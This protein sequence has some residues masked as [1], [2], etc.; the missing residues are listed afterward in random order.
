MIAAWGYP[1]PVYPADPLTLDAG[2]ST[3]RLDSHIEY[4]K[5]APHSL[6]IEQAS[7]HA[8]SAN[9]S[10]T[11][12][13]RPAFGYTRD[14]VWIRF[15]IENST[16]APAEIFIEHEYPLIDSLDFYIPSPHGYSAVRR[17]DHLPF[18]NRD[19]NYRNQVF[20]LSVPP[21]VS[22]YY[23]CMQSRGSISASMVAWAP[24]K[25]ES[26]RRY[27]LPLL[28]VYYGIMLA[29]AFY[30]L[31]IFVT[32]KEKSYAYLLFFILSLAIVSLVHSGLASQY[33]WPDSPR[34]SN[35]SHP[36]FS[37]L[38]I[39]FGLQFTCAFLNVS[40]HSPRIYRVCL[41]WAHILLGISVSSLWVDYY[42][43]TQLSAIVAGITVAM[44]TLLGVR[45]L[46]LKMREAYFY[47][48]AW[49]SFILGILLLV[50]KSYALV[51]EMFLTTWGY[52]VGSSITMLLFSFG[53]ADKMNTYR[54]E[55]MKALRRLRESEER[56]RL[57]V[58][59]AHDG[60]MLLM[61]VK[62]VYANASL[63]RMLGY[64]EREFSR[65]TLADLLPETPKGREM[66]FSYYNNRLAGLEAPSQ[67]EAQMLTKRNE[68]IDVI[69]AASRI[70]IDE[71]VGA[72]SIITNIS[73]MKRAEDTI[74]MQFREIQV[75]Y[76]RLEALNKRLLSAH[77][78]LLA[79]NEN[80]TREKERIAATL[81][82]IGDAVI[83]IDIEGGVLLMNPSAERLTGHTVEEAGAK[84][85]AD[86][87]SLQDLKSGQELAG[88]FG[89]VGAG[90]LQDLADLP[91]VM[92]A[93]D[94]RERIVEVS[95][96]PVA[97]S[98]D[99]PGGTVIAI[100]DITEKI[101]LE[102]ELIKMSK[103]ESLGVLAGGIAHDF[104]NLLTAIIGNLGLAKL[105][106]RDNPDFHGFMEKIEQACL[107]A[108]NL[109]RQLLTFSKG[110]APVKKT[111][112]IGELLR[113]SA[114]F[115]LT[116]SPVRCEFDF[117]NGLWPVDI[118][119]DQVSQVLNNI[120][121]NAMQAMPGG[122]TISVRAHNLGEVFGLPLKQGRYVRISIRD[123]GVGIPRKFLGRIFDPY[124]TTKEHG[125]GLGLA[126]SYS[127]IKRHGG[128]I[129]VESE[130][131]RGTAFHIYLH[132]SDGEERNHRR[133]DAPAEKR[134]GRVLVM[135]DEK[136]VRDVAI[137]MLSYFGYRVDGA[138]DGAEAA[139]MYADA[140]EGGDPY[141]AVIMDLVVPGGIGGVECLARIRELDP[142]AFII[143]SSG[144]SNDPVM[145]GYKGYGFDGVMM[146]P[147]VLQDAISL[148]DEA[149]GRTEKPIPD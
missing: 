103:I 111:A 126:S 131:R 18:S 97:G 8:F 3:A 135:D 83:T 90:A 129:D 5:D 96:A 43:M 138:R 47:V 25:F 91:I 55:K 130:E 33:L 92:T 11:P 14:A 98:G 52:Q 29:L 31:F 36:L 1:E 104:N 109:T 146:K 136:A 58:E 100:R 124:F 144:Y 62:P 143:V 115:I 106:I 64:D 137:N 12:F 24:E 57:L 134:N 78:E 128:Y 32:M 142:A 41:I 37:F 147:Y 101:K 82:A 118:D 87:F 89:R 28:G 132:A 149:T 30:H 85:L 117:E 70:T 72:I 122:G 9:F 119:I 48:L 86:L 68:I 4:Y 51:P 73:Q 125:S 110:G 53:I 39:L 76:G 46:M 88:L 75:Q 22:T 45:S 34:W 10:P 50:L 21:G 108:A 38:T 2:F 23:L 139:A 71:G 141:H 6:S 63:V 116:G 95:G 107:R 60:I 16:P 94:G 79:M 40:E 15:S 140:M 7:T 59:N 99:R 49:L 93:P 56:Y 42:Y 66:V 113:E 44:M 26:M 35:I 120:L 13:G 77:N 20:R 123:N 61:G 74:L 65:L 127:I 81:R 54:A 114:E 84:N 102:K 133:S 19:L 17:G 67:Y 69:I 145:A 27:E 105:T 148:L 121:I 112:S 80:L